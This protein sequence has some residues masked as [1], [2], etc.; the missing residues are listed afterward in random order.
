MHRGGSKLDNINVSD[1]VLI[2]FFS[3]LSQ[4]PQAYLALNAGTSIKNEPIILVSVLSTVFGM[5]I[6]G[7]V[8]INYLRERMIEKHV[9]Q[10][11][12][13]TSTIVILTQYL[14]FVW[15]LSSLLN[16][17]IFINRFPDLFVFS[18]AISVAILLISVSILTSE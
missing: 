15:T 13:I 1:M 10:T 4:V 7:I 14:I 12:L 11:P 9:V 6:V 2:A 3:L 16:H 17:P 18:Q 8:V 5:I